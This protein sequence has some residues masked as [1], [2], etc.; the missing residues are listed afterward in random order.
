M[1]EM[2]RQ[3]VLGEDIIAAMKRAAKM[4]EKGFTYSYDMLGEAAHTESDAK[5]YHLSYADAIKQ[6]AKHC[7]S[8]DIREN[9]GISI[10]LSA[11]HPRYELGQSE[12]V[13]RELVLST[14]RLARMARKA[15]MGLN[16]DAEEADRLDLSLDVIEA[17]LRDPDLAG[18]DGFGVVVQAF[19]KRCNGV[20]DWLHALAT[21]LDRKIMVR[22]VKGAYWDTE[23]KRAQVEGTQNFPVFTR[24]AATDVAYICNAQK[25]LIMTDRI[26]PQ[27]ATHNAHTVAAIL[28]LATDKSTFEFQRL[29]GMGEALHDIVLTDEQT[30]CRIY[31]PVGAHRD[32]LA[33]LV[34]RLLENGANSSFVNQIIDETVPHQT[35]P[36]IPSKRSPAQPTPLLRCQKTSSHRAPIRS[37][38][39]YTATPSSA[40]ARRLA[41]LL[42]KPSAGKQVH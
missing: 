10:K 32:L 14:K 3:F 5:R 38:G 39:I 13:M 37:A 42:H 25:L 26:Y 27:F 29:H 15:N 16:I 22:L 11:L 41:P 31:A 23:I 35:S 9:P 28:E 33:Y 40:K 1:K 30:R 12:R 19:G 24:K 21:E 18:W 36:L 20:I 7:K 17:V 34:R 6:L 4:E 2:G 8:D